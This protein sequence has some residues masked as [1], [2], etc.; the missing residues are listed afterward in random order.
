LTGLDGKGIAMA[1]QQAI[2]RSSSGRTAFKNIVRLFPALVI[3]AA[4]LNTVSC[5]NNNGLLPQSGGGGGATGSASLT[6]TSTPTA[7]AAALAF[8]TNFNDAQVSSFTRNTATG[9][10]TH[11]GQVTAGAKHGPRGVVAAPSGNF[12]YV[13]NINDDKIYEFSVDQTS[14]A[15]TP[16]S[17]P[18]VS[19][20]N[21]TAPDELAINSAGTLMWVTGG[22]GTVTSYTVDATTGQLTKK[23]SIDGFNTPFGIAVHPSLAVIY[24]S[25]LK[26]GLIQPMSYNTKNGLLAK[27]FPAVASSDPNAKIPAALTI[28]AA[29]AALFT[30]D[31]GNGE[32][33]SFAIDGSGALTPIQAATN[34]KVSD[35]PVGIGVGTNTGNEYVFTA[36]WGG[37]SVSSFL[38]NNSTTMIGPPTVASGY[39]APKGL[40]VDPQNV[41]VYTANSADGTVA[42]SKIKGACLS[43]ICAGTTVSAESPHKAGSGPFG[44]TLVH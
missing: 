38:I 9:A 12:L 27:N 40:V 34:S 30:P 36:N 21:Q 19:N 26:T 23:S 35:G 20:G 17:T 7:A 25:D 4:T 16:L 29:G 31:Q 13:A 2:R 14:G 15:L 5:K 11:T 6:P 37:A 39:N 18:S 8:V 1:S 22:A 28:D 44:I 42:V 33:S 10:L 43:Q 41:F 3:M 32:V 24:V